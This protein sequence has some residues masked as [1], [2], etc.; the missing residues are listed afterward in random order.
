[1]DE[2]RLDELLRRADAASSLTDAP[3]SSS[4]TS[5][6]ASK[7]TKKRKRL[8]EKEQDEE[9]LHQQE[10]QQFQVTRLLVQP[11]NVKNGVMKDYQLDGLNWLIRLYETNINGILADEMGLGK[12]LQSISLLA[13]IRQFKK[14]NGPH[15]VVVPKST[16]G[17]WENEF[18]KWCPEIRTFRFHGDKDERA[19]QKEKMKKGK[20]D[21]CLTTF[22]IAMI[23]SNALKKLNW[24]VLIVDE[25]HRLKNENSKLFQELNQLKTRARLLLTG[26]PLQNNLHELWALLFFLLPDIFHSASDFDALFKIASS[27]EQS[28]MLQKLHKIL[29]PFLL[30]RLKSEVAQSL[31]PKKEILVLVDMP[32]LQKEVYKSVLL[33]DMETVQGNSK[34][35]SRLLNTMMQLRKAANHPYLFDGV[36]DRTLPPLDEHMIFNSGKMIVL[37]KLIKKLLAQ[38]SRVLIFSQMARQLDIL[39]DYCVY[40]DLKY[41]RIDG[42]T[43]SEERVE[44]IFDFNKAGSQIQVFLLTTRA[45]GLGI[46]LASADIVIIYDSDWNPQADLQAQDRAHRIGQKKPVIVYRFVVRNSIE[47]KVVERA[48]LKLRLDALVIQQ[49]RATSSN[50]NKMSKDAMLSMIRF[51]ADQIFHAEENIDWNEDIDTI[52][53]R[54]E[55]HTLKLKE[56]T[57]SQASKISID[58]LSQSDTNVD[59]SV[60]EAFEME[61]SGDSKDS[62]LRF[63][64]NMVTA[65]GKREKRSRP[66]STSTTEGAA[67]SASGSSRSFVRALG[68][69]SDFQFFNKTRLQ[70]LQSKEAQRDLTEQEEEE[71]NVLISEGFG[72]WNQREFSKFLIGCENCG[73]DAVEQ[74]AK[75][76]PTKTLEEVQKYHE[77]FFCRY[78]ELDDHE[79]YIARIEKG[80]KKLAKVK[81]IQATLSRVLQSGSGESLE[82]KYHSGLRSKGFTVENDRFLLEQ[83]CLLGYGEWEKVRGSIRK[84]EDFRFDYYFKSRSG[85]ELGRRVDSLMRILPQL[86]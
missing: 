28:T 79:K 29:K 32:Q 33:K 3:I 30:R 50:A 46:N 54:G 25:A 78:K 13:Y 62:D 52:L 75:F 34:E 5:S 53:S 86:K 16:L 80:E 73:R 11:G 20:F 63:L 36:E 37:D 35:R 57:E 69:I 68:L 39:E 15:L 60:S 74:I 2:D 19:E 4:T 22:Q 70:E 10:D 58:V 61:L 83:T 81:E 55:Q 44:Q 1:M 72:N 77:V 51:G 56:K 84:C 14:V 66:Q 43:S 31:P 24:H 27:G 59:Q 9:F 85:A 76:I 67:A 26:T 7:R 18:N 38:K 45:G 42:S 17:N 41:C 48:E 23:E 12:T 65:L 6:S 40:R 8:S 21:V 49:G 71:R 64:T 82:L 47:E